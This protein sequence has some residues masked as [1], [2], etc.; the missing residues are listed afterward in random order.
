MSLVS[1]GR[2]LLVM[3]V[4]PTFAAAQGNTDPTSSGLRNL[5]RSNRQVVIAAAEQMPETDYAFR[6]T[7]E[8][9]TFGQVI[10]HITNS[11]YAF[12]SAALGVASPKQ[13]DW[14]KTTAKGEL[15]QALK[16]SFTFCDGAYDKLTDASGA[17]IVKV[18]GNDRARS[19]PLIFNLAHNNEHYGNLVTYMRLKGMVPPSSQR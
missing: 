10:G 7:V 17:E 14:E 4:T 18:F 19:F 16:E 5:Y 12:C 9:R 6:A 3:S 11:Q 15:V 8:V 1:C 13:V 2:L